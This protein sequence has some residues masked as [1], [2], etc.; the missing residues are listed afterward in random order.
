MDLRACRIIAFAFVACHLLGSQLPAGQ[1]APKTIKAFNFCAGSNTKWGKEHPDLSYGFPSEP[2]IPFTDEYLKY[3]DSA[4]HDA[5]AKTGIDG[6]MLDWLRMP[7]R[8]A[9]GGHWLECEKKLYAQLMGE[10]F[11]GEGRSL[12]AARMTESGRRVVARC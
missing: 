9:N 2:H 6:F 1:P 10:P 11:P 7:S 8:A 5:V 3:L 12:P 4:I